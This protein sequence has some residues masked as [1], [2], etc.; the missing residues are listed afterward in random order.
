MKDTTFYKELIKRQAEEFIGLKLIQDKAES[1]RI[2]FW[3]DRYDGK[4]AKG[5]SFVLLEECVQLEILI[6]KED[7]RKDVILEKSEMFEE[8]HSKHWQ[9]H[10]KFAG[11]G[12]WIKYDGFLKDGSYI[13]EKLVTPLYEIMNEEFLFGLKV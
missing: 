6:I 2:G 13:F 8:I 9:F 10:E 11:Y 3:G 4:C 5:I 7:Y 12:H 1:N